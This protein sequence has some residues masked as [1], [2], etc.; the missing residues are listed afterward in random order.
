MLHH[1]AKALGAHLSFFD[2]A[3]GTPYGRESWHSTSEAGA[4]G[5]LGKLVS[6]AVCLG[7]KVSAVVAFILR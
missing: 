5:V 7:L 2:P 3:P 1:S 6:V 4:I